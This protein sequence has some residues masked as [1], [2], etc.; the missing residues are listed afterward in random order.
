M[1]RPRRPLALLAFAAI[2]AAGALASAAGSTAQPAQPPPGGAVAAPHELAAEAGEAM[3]RAGGTAFDAVV[4]ATFVQ[5][6]VNPQSSGLGGGG[7]AVWRDA[8]G[9]TGALD[10][11]ET[12]PSFFDDAVYERAGRDSAHGAWS[13]G[14]PGEPLGLAELHVLG[15]RL[16]WADVVEPARRL[17]TGGFP[18]GEDL[19]KA[20]SASADAVAADPGLAADFTRDGQPLQAGERCRRPA[21]GETLEYLQIHGG[22][23]FYDGPLAVSLS[24]FVARAGAPWTEAELSAYRTRRREPLRGRYRG[25]EVVTMPPP[26][27]GGIALLETLLL[28]EQAGHARMGP[29]SPEALRTL[30]QAFSHAFADRATYLGDPDFVSM[31]LS[32]LLDPDLATRLLRAGPARGPVPAARAGLAGERG[33]S[34]ALLPPKDDHGTSHLSAMDGAGAAVALTTTINL[35]FGSGMQD[36]RTGVLLNDEMDDF[37][38]HPGVPN[39]FGLVQGSKNAPGPGKRPL[40]SMTPT[41]VLDGSGRAIL[42]LGGAGGPKIITGT[43]QT[44]IHMVDRGLSPEDA[45]AR[46]R[47]HHQ[48]LPPAVMLEAGFDGK[49]AEVLRS[50]GFPLLPMERGGVVQAVRFDPS[51]PLW[52]GGA[53]PRAHGGVRVLAPAP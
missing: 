29:E 8:S 43:L 4:A 26:S 53:D 44:L 48:W 35:L 47:L 45:L 40:S 9:G 16:P 5:G 32:A 15:G 34:A 22:A 25:H 38:A 27:S 41:L 28:L 52:D 24:G 39:A 17:A 10:F 36:P 6:V 30:A 14:I 51:G 11:R 42:A 19:A 37:A 20:I 46:P 3:L 13:I 49:T 33:D 12:A 21:L 2:V 50:E 1:P 18:V 7:F 23:A 31:P